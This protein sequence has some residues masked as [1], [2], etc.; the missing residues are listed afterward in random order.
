MT[1][2]LEASG[3]PFQSGRWGFVEEFWDP[4]F[5]RLLSEQWPPD[6]FLDPAEY[7]TKS[8]DI[9][10]RYAAGAGNDPEYLADFPAYRAAYA[11]LRSDEFCQ[12]LSD[13]V[14]DGVLRTCYQIHLTRSCW[15]SS[16]IPHQDSQST[17]GR[18]NLLLF[19]D[20]SGGPRS[21]GLAFWKDGDF[22]EKIFEPMNLRNTCAYYDMSEDFYH[23]FE[24]VRFGAFRRT[25]N[26]TYRAAA[27]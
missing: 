7:V 8:Y 5:H 1:P 9:G 4:A 27:P 12:R 11:F 20:G 6:R 14:G 3:E 10:M 13:L 18:L 17:P 2:A 25:I 23:G 22:R 15:G 21:G 16:V 26:A 24:P 19:I